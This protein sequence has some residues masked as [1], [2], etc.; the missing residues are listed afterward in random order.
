MAPG[1]TMLGG[2]R[3]RPI[4]VMH[5][6]SLLKRKSEKFPEVLICESGSTAEGQRFS[7]PDTVPDG[8]STKTPD[9]HD[10]HGNETARAVAGGAQCPN[11][12]RRKHLPLIHICHGRSGDKGD[13]A[14]IGVICRDPNHYPHVREHLTAQNVKSCAIVQFLFGPLCPHNWTRLS[15]VF[16][17]RRNVLIQE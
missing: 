4:P 13:L 15:V 3:P 14:N 8:A 17:V 7:L 1:T 6:F 5:V 10:T 9:V 12:Q 11:A 2:S 16:D